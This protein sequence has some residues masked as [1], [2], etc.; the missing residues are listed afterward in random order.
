MK[1]IKNYKD[2]LF[3]YVEIKSLRYN[4][5]DW[6]DNLLFMDT[7]LHFQHFENGRWVEKE[8]STHD[9]AQIRKKYPDNY[10]DNIEW[11]GEP[12]STFIEF[13]DFG[14]RGKNAFI[15]DVKDAILKGNYGPSWEAFI[16]TLKEGRLFAI[17]TT[18][19]H[20][21]STIRS[22]VEYIIYNVLN[23]DDRIEMVENLQMFNDMFKMKTNDAIIQYL[24]NC[25]F[26]GI[27]SQAFKDEFGYVPSGSK[28]NQGKQDAINKFT[29]YVREFSTKTK[30]PLK[31]GFSDDDINYSRAAK[32]LFMSMEKSI[33]FPEKFYVFDT[34]NRNIEGGVRV[35][36]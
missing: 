35:Q 17:I 28:T 29:T 18:R 13:R 16:E 25:Y 4:I 15:E 34:S 11:K 10:M 21:P 31:I 27:S 20:E 36:I 12:S 6:D 8:I 2:F 14:P 26:M 33:D 9:F 3:E 30:L 7:P 22:A 32:E 1:K 23:E 19:G 5:F 24:N